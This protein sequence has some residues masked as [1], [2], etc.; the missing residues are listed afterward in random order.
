MISEMKYVK[1]IT[2]ALFVAFVLAPDAGAFRGRRCGG[3]EIPRVRIIE[4]RSDIVDLSGKKEFTFKWSPHEGRRYGRKYYDFRIYRGDQALG[5]NLIYKD[6]A[7]PDSIELL[8]DPGMF[9]DGQVYTWTI[10][11][12]YRSRGKSSRT[13]NT[14]EVINKQNGGM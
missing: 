6:K 14:F 8:L 2:I 10:R 7:A 9:K 11:Q 5:P 12:V 13:Y 4:P 1:T 3:V